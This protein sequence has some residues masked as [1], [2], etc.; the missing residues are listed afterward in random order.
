MKIIKFLVS[1]LVCASLTGCYE[2]DQEQSAIDT[3]EKTNVSFNFQTLDVK[4]HAETRGTAEDSEEYEVGDQAEYQLKT[5]VLYFFDAKS[6]G[7]VKACK[8]EGLTLDKEEA[9]YM[10]YK[11]NE[12]SVDAGTY[13][14][15]AIGN[16]T[17][18]I[19]VAN[20]DQLLANIDA[21]TYKAGQLSTSENGFLMTNRGSANLGQVIEKRTT[22]QPE[23]IIS[24]TVERCVA[25]MEV[26]KSDDIYDLKN[27]NEEVYAKV[28]LSGCYFLNLATKFYSFRH[29]A[30]LTSL[31][32]PTWTVGTNFGNVN[33][34]NGYVCDPYFFNK[35]VSAVGFNNPDGFY[36]HHLSTA[37]ATAQFSTLT[38]DYADNKIYG[39]ENCAIKDAQKHGYSTG[40]LFKAVLTPNDNVYDENGSKVDASSYDKLYYFN[41]KFYNSIAALIKAGVKAT[42]E[43]TEEELLELDVKTFDGSAGKF[44]CYYKYWIRHLDNDNPTVMGT[45]EF[46]IVR[47]NLYRMK[48]TGISGLG[49]GKIIDD[50]DDPDEDETFI[51]VLLNVKPWIVRDNQNII[52]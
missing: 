39:L 9:K 41:Y 28:D 4:S 45:M 43:M 46:G 49:S 50:P 2:H 20:E 36:T 26:C 47:N 5:V 16:T 52:L 24:I 6:K 8:V 13:D 31:T 25:R 14:I 1:V 18:V 37:A 34:G 51:K 27:Q 30:D 19:E 35:K 44:N 29:V 17:N 23:Q 40:I 38:K 12:I 22:E 32:E 15:F 48:V 11:S 10:I 21:E 42:P 3:S 33:D 7:L